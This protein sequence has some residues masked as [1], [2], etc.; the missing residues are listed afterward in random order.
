[1]PYEKLASA[2]NILKGNLASAWNI[3]EGTSGDYTDLGIARRFGG[4]E[5]AYSLRDI[6][7][8][9]GPVVRVRRD[10]GTP[11]EEDFSANQ[12]ASGVLETFVGSGN[13]GFVSKWYDQSGNGRDAT[14]TTTTQQPQLVINGE[15]VKNS[16]GLP[17]PRFSRVSDVNTELDFTGVNANNTSVYVVNEQTRNFSNAL[18][19]KDGGNFRIRFGRQADSSDG[20]KRKVE[21]EIKNAGGTVRLYGT[22]NLN[23]QPAYGL[24]LGYVNSGGTNKVGFNSVTATSTLTLEDTYT[25]NQIFRGDNNSGSTASNHMIPEIIIYSGDK[26]VETEIADNIKDYYNI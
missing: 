19:A 13:N 16:G 22:T 4:A 8:M 23:T 7:A 11:S 17:S 25:W 1:M 3:L 20:N 14:Q 24:Y 26:L 21:L 12:V 9:N 15:I 18:V 5:A 10:S 6:G 2:E